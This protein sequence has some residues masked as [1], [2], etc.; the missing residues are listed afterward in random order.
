MILCICLAFDLLFI[1]ELILNSIAE[2]SVYIS[3]RILFYW[4][5]PVKLWTVPAIAVAE[6]SFKRES[7]TVSKYL[8]FSK[9]LD[10]ARANDSST[11]P[12]T[13]A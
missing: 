4:V 9:C 5:L 1:L 12:L 3:D 8:R 13:K 11:I 7:Y 2:I 6:E 10:N